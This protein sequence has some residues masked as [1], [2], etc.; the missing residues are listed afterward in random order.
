[1]EGNVIII[2]V[3]FAESDWRAAHNADFSPATRQLLFIM[4][5][6]VKGTKIPSTT[7]KG[8]KYLNTQP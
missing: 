6:P 7:S 4:G 1:M 8:S 5:F 2:C 3:A